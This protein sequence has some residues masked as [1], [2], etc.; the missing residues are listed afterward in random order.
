MF[1]RANRRAEDL[2][3]AGADVKGCGSVNGHCCIGSKW[4]FSNGSDA[5]FGADKRRSH[6]HY[7]PPQE[8]FDASA[9]G[10]SRPRC[11]NATVPQQAG[12]RRGTATSR[13]TT[14]GTTSTIESGTGIY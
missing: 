10:F 7:T 6:V 13:S 9:D 12:L 4:D 1:G 11:L 14:S 2:H 5:T 3:V 8:I